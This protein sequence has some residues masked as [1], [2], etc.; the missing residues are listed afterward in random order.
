[1]YEIG[2]CANIYIICSKTNRQKAKNSAEEYAYNM[3]INV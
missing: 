1:M 2:R 3:K